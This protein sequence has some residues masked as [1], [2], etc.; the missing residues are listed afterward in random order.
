MSSSSPS[1]NSSSSSGGGQVPMVCLRDFETFA[2]RLLPKMALDYYRSGADEE[3]TLTENRQAFN[4]YFVIPRMLRDVSKV[5]ISSS[6]LGRR[7]AFPVCIAPTAMQRMAHPDGEVASAKG[8]KSAGIGFTLSTIATS[9]IEEIASGVGASLRFFQLY[10]YKDRNITVQLIRRAETG[11][12][13]AVFLTVDTPFF[14]KRRSDNRNRFKLPPHLRMANFDK[15]D[16]K[17][18]GV[19]QSKTES[20]LNEYAASLFETS[21]TWKDVEWLK[22]ITKLPVVL[23]GILSREDALMAVE[24]G[25]AGICVSN[26]G[27][28]QLD[29]VPATIDCLR[30]IVSAVDGRVEVY[31]DGGVRT[32]TDVLKAIALGAKTVFVGRPV[33]YALAYDVR[34]LSHSYSFICS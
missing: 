32:G 7:I 5:D 33:L 15:I 21:I 25:V 16:F 34:T 23:K 19:N 1:A 6:I 20:G 4:R 17:G 10:I 22:T 12:F 11:G 30:D 13:S 2:V 14:G 28:R 3:I 27:G 31:L 18:S 24:C 9:S 8:A 26:H 29:S